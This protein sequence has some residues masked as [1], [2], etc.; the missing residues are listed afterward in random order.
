MVYHVLKDGSVVKDITGY[1]VKVKDAEALY[2]LMGKISQR[3]KPKSK[4]KS[5]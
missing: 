3:A 1:I 2:N 4:P 5:A